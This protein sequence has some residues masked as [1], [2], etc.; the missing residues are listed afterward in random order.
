[1]WS[2]KSY[3][4][5]SHKNRKRLTDARNKRAAARPLARLKFAAI[6][7]VAICMCLSA[8][9]YPPYEAWQNGALDRA[10]AQL[11][12]KTVAFTRNQGLE[13]QE[14]LVDGRYYTGKDEL[15]STLGIGRGSAILG[16]DLDQAQNRLLAL[17]WVKNASVERR[18]PNTILVHLEEKKPLALWQNKGALVLI[19][20]RGAVILGEEPA[21]FDNLLLI[22]GSD[23]PTFAQELVGILSTSPA[24]F[25]RVAV[26]SRIGERRWDL[27]MHNGIVVKLPEQQMDIAW[28]RLQELQ[29]SSNILDQAILSIDLRLPDRLYIE[30]DKDIKP[31][32]V[33]NDASGKNT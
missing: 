26:A 22:I 24:I 23:A 32:A 16:I 13:V 12:E 5:P 27:K 10:Y 31:N 29:D 19:D 20:E 30:T 14:I 33:Q 6:K 1:M 28:S 25:K 2:L 11:A 9:V 21:I 18:L 15:L 7:T 8:V 3:R 4:P 17:P